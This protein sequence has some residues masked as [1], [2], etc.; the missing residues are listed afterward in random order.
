M[1]GTGSQF[2]EGTD[3][4]RSSSTE[5]GQTQGER[6]HQRKGKVMII[7]RKTEHIAHT[8]LPHNFALDQQG[9]NSFPGGSV[10]KESACHAGDPGSIPG[11]GRSSGERK[12]YTHSS[13]LAWRIQW[14]EEPG[15]LQSIGSQ[16]L[17]M[18]E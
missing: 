7:K 9:S 13:I 8:V 11:L 15:G 16:E 6:E 1:K 12:E 14:T 18:T 4:P 17:D 10:S 3:V 5:H 2:C